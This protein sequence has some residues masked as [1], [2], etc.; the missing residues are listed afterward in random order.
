MLHAAILTLMTLMPASMGD[1]LPDVG[2]MLVADRRIDIPHLPDRAVA[3]NPSIARHAGK[4]Y[5]VFRVDRFDMGWVTQMQLGIVQLDDH[6]RVV[7]ETT[8]LDTRDLPW[9]NH[10]SEDP[11]LIDHN[12]A[13]YVVFNATH[14][15]SMNSRRAMR[16]AHIEPPQSP[17]GSFGVTAVSEMFPE[18]SEYRPWQEKNW[19]PFSFE[20]ELHLVYRTN[21]PKVYRV[22]Q[23]VLKAMPQE[24]RVQP[25]SETFSPLPF[26]YGEMRGGTPAIYAEDLGKYVSFF[27]ARDAN[28]YGSGHKMH[29]FIGFYAFDAEPP[30]AISH[31]LPEPIIVPWMSNPQRPYLEVA[32]PG[33]FLFE[34]DMIHVLYGKNDQ[35]IRVLTLDKDQ[36]YDALVP[37]P[38]H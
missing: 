28:N 36:L 8:L 37:Q 33:G 32:Y 11:R 25:V 1:R 5:L 24:I 35:S 14:D 31:L 13:L 3:Y 2:T 38:T 21:P 30:F 9:A 17:G 20:G 19:A 26:Y 16:I 23:D 7:S 27:H 4:L 29:Y 18:G 22:P 15:G 34:G 6:F 12:G 10:T